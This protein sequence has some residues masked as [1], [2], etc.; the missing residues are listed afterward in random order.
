MGSI[1]VVIRKKTISHFNSTNLRF[2][3]QQKET[4]KKIAF[5]TNYNPVNYRGERKGGEK[6]I[7]KTWVLPCKKRTW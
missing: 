1:K 7:L 3:L 6:I 5:V 4:E 2:L